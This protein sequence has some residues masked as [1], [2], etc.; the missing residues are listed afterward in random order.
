MESISCY[1]SLIKKLF[2]ICRFLLDNKILLNCHSMTISNGSALF[3]GKYYGQ[4]DSMQ[5]AKRNYELQ[6]T[7]KQIFLSLLDA[8]Q[9]ISPV[10]SCRVHFETRIC[11]QTQRTRINGHD[12]ILVKQDFSTILKGA[13]SR[14]VNKFLSKL[15]FAVF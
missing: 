4:A 7:C 3:T 14:N 5:Y 11:N 9:N 13:G 8:A 1:S 2:T 10:V 12:H 6:F 15:R